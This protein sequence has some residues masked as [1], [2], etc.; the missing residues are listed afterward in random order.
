MLLT[1][2]TRVIVLSAAI[3][4]TDEQFIVFRDDDTVSI[5]NDRRKTSFFARHSER[6]TGTFL[7]DWPRRDGEVP[8]ARSLLRSDQVGAS[9]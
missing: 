5:T 9:G 8:A 1:S 4:V 6:T 3:I 2:E 7:E